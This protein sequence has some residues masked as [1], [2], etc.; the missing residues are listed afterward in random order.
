M[1]GR[2]GLGTEGHARE[3]TESS[4][5]FKQGRDSSIRPLKR[6]AGTQGVAVGVTLTLRCWQGDTGESGEKSMIQKEGT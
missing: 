6:K 4:T 2:Q 1:Q 3:A 5:G